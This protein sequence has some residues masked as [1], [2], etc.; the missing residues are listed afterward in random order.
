VAHRNDPQAPDARA[1]TLRE[2]QVLGY[3][4]LGHSN[5]LIGYELG[6]HPSSVARHLRDAGTKLGAR[7]RVQLIRRFV[8]G[9]RDVAS[10]FE[11]PADGGDTP[12]QP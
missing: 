8:E 10:V 11:D 7:S 3:A 6:L 9:V 1:L 4:A 2:R 5:K 12:S